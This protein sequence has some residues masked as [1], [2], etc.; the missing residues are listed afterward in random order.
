MLTDAFATLAGDG[1]LFGYKYEGFWKPA[2]TL[3][4]RAELD[5]AYH[6]GERPWMPWGSAVAQ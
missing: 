4:E 5:A 2:D 6:N 3:K 1:R